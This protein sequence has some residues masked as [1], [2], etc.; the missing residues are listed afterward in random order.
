[1]CMVNML[2]HL[3]PEKH[4]EFIQYRHTVHL[5]YLVLHLKYLYFTCV[6]PI[7]GNIVLL[8]F[9]CLP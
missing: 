9:I 4:S 2:T 5:L 7:E 8:H 6:F 3:K 1:M